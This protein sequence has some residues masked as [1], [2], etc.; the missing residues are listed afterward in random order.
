VLRVCVVGER[1]RECVW[2]E[3]ECVGFK[4]D[5]LP[6]GREERPS[7]VGLTPD[8]GALGSTQP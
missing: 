8:T 3:R 6:S 4:V 5:T 7:V 2:L 1:E